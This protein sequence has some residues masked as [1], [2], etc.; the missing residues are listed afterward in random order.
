[1]KVNNAHAC[2][3]LEQEENSCVKDKLFHKF[4]KHW[5][6]CSDQYPNMNSR[7]NSLEGVLQILAFVCTLPHLLHF[8]FPLY[9]APSSITA[10]FLLNIIILALLFPS[11]SR[12][13]STASEKRRPADGKTLNKSLY[14]LKR[15]GGRDK[16]PSA[17]ANHRRKN[18]PLRTT[19][20]VE[21][22]RIASITQAFAERQQF[23]SSEDVA[24]IHHIYATASVATILYIGKGRSQGAT[25]P[26]NPQ[27]LVPP[28]VEGPRERPQQQRSEQLAN[29][30]CAV[31]MD[32]R[33][34]EFISSFFARVRAEIRESRD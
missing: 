17:D 34:D 5:R 28:V 12:K 33:F 10:F 23:H 29:L 31:D 13:T 19:K 11:I 9:E 1:M 32:K 18:L 8:S 6:T 7:E 16:A 26:T 14:N 22:R 27:Q 30:T 25:M 21:G 20:S 15:F 24:A 3:T 4:Y 2:Q